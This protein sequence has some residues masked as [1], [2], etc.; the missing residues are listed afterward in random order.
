MNQEE[1]VNQLLPLL[2]EKLNATT[3]KTT[4]SIFDALHIPENQPRLVPAHGASASRSLAVPEAAKEAISFPR[5]DNRLTV[6][7]IKDL[8]R[9]NLEAE[10]GLLQPQEIDTELLS[11]FSA[12][13]RGKDEQLIK[14]QREI[15]VS[16]RP[17]IFTLQF[18]ESQEITD[19]ATPEFVASIIHKLQD[20]L[21]LSFHCAEGIRIDRR[22]ALARYVKWGTTLTEACEKVDS[23]AA[24]D[25]ELF[26]P[27]FRQ[28]FHQ[29]AKNW[30]ASQ[31]HL[32][33]GK[34]QNQNHHPNNSFVHRFNGRGRGRKTSYFGGGRAEKNNTWGKVHGDGAPASA[35]SDKSHTQS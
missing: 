3:V 10:D 28:L 34:P 31:D 7:C 23:S 19:A 18:L 12:E 15:Y 27:E 25:A 24:F 4:G 26:G 22:L 1:L 9:N 21:A 30:K 29:E 20:T 33:D 14:I 17:V 11:L 5:L 2:Q 13:A 16:M 35:P 6:I 32:R 8:L